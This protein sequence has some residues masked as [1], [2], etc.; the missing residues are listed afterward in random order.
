[1]NDY[2]LYNDI[3]RGFKQKPQFNTQTESNHL[4]TLEELNQDM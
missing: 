3:Y 4:K 1:M 2:G